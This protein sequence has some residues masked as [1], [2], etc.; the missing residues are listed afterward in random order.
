MKQNPIPQLGAATA[1]VQLLSENPSLP[2]ASWS[3]GEFA[4]HGH[5][6]DGGFGALGRYAGVLGGSIRPL[7]NDYPSGGRLVRVHRLVAMWRDIPVHV[8]VVLPVA[9]DTAVAA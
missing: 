5:L 4:L 7:G 8:D 1:L 6:H 2:M 3:V 9:A